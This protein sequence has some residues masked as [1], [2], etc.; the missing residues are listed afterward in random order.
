VGRV[1]RR[2]CD[3]G[4]KKRHAEPC[5]DKVRRPAGRRGGHGSTGYTQERKHVNIILLYNHDAATSL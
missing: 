5:H 1:L 3:V 4:T 2:F